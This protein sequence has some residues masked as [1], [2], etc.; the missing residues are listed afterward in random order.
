MRGEVKIDH[1]K[2]AAFSINFAL[3]TSQSSIFLPSGCYVYRKKSAHYHHKSTCNT[4][5]IF[6]GTQ[7]THG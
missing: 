7:F 4:V 6:M 1:L 3:E 5:I 2:Q